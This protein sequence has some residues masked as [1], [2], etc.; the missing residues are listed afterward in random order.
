MATDEKGTPP[1]L[2]V[3]EQDTKLKAALKV[4]VEG[5]VVDGKRVEIEGA[6]GLGLRL[7]MQVQK[8]GEAWRGLARSE[9]DWKRARLSLEDRQGKVLA[10][11]ASPVWPPDF[12][13]AGETMELAKMGLVEGSQHWSALASLLAIKEAGMRGQVRQ[14]EEAA[15]Q[16]PR[17]RA[18][19]AD[20]EAAHSWVQQVQE[21]E[22]SAI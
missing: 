18:A 1:Y 14:M 3:S 16:L 5:M 15:V 17:A 19:L 11:V 2:V 10:S 6:G 8:T 13:D 12:K 9:G 4:V 21:A 22:V 7:E 20:W